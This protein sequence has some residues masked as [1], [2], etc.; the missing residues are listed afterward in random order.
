MNSGLKRCVEPAA[1]CLQPDSNLSERPLGPKLVDLLACA[2][3]GCTSWGLDLEA[4]RE[5]L[6]LFG[7][8]CTTRGLTGSILRSEKPTLF[9]ALEFAK[10]K[11]FPE[12]TLDSLPWYDY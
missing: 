10:N 5:L 3:P 2:K 8:A 7:C 12:K 6:L 9:K 11:N 1:V 4:E